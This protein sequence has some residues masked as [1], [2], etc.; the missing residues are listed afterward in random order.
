M[1]H[2]AHPQ[3]R[4]E[5]A[6]LAQVRNDSLLEEDCDIYGWQLASWRILA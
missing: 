1:K 5:Q 2:P 4:A 6:M 3:L